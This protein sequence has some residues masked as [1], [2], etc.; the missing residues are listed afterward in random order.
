MYR[1]PYKVVQRSL[2]A[3]FGIFNGTEM[4]ENFINGN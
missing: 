2:Y 4:N 3:L 1:N